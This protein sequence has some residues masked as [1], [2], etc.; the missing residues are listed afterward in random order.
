MKVLLL[1]VCL[2]TPTTVHAQALHNETA[3]H[4]A[5][6]ASYATVG[7]NI[8]L[9]VKG[10]CWDAV[11]RKRG[12]AMTGARIGTTWLAVALL[13]KAFPRDRPCAPECG[14]DSP[15][16]DFPSGHTAFAFEAVE[17]SRFAVS[18]PLAVGSGGLRLAA[19]KHDLIGVISGAI[20]G[21][22]AGHFLR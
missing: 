2:L 16:S 21:S 17:G 9:D 11:D 7:L 14:I 18:I 10:S 15:D 3:R 20:V 1:T 8:A 19:G 5:D 22:L 13:K 6:I 12:C 4:V